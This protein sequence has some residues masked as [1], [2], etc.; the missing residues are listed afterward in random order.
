MDGDACPHM[1]EGHGGHGMMHGLNLTEQRQKIGNAMHEQMQ[2]QRD[3]T[4]RY[5]DKLPAADKAAMQKEQEANR[6][7]QQKTIRDTLDSMSRRSSTRCRRTWRNVAPSVKSSKPGRPSAPRKPSNPGTPNCPRG[8]SPASSRCPCRR[9]CAMRSLF[10]AHLRHPGWP[11][12]W[13]AFPAARPGAQPGQLDP[14]PPPSACATSPSNGARCSS[15]TA[16][17]RRRTT[18]NATG[19]VATSTCRCSTIR[20]AAGTRHLR[21]AAGLFEARQHDQG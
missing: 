11:S 17:R 1:K 21:R 5:L 6:A 2:T 19:T 13:V 16:R 15:T 18:S 4:K 3:I 7:K 14:R 8:A 20:R 10:L 9:S 12:P